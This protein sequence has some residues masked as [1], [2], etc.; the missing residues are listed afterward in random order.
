[1]ARSRLRLKCDGSRAETRFRLS[2]KRTSPFKSSGGRQFS[3]LLAAEVCTSAAIMLDTPCSEVVWK[4]L[5]TNSIRQF[6]FHFPSRASPYVITFQLDSSTVHA[7]CTLKY[8]HN[9]HLYTAGF[10]TIIHIGTYDEKNRLCGLCDHRISFRL[11]SH[12]L[13]YKIQHVR[14]ALELDYSCDSRLIPGIFKRTR[15][16]WF[17]K[18]E[19]CTN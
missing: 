14:R 15:N 7:T 17:H 8:V 9:V 5:A 4:V 10:L 1:M 2:A 19:F 11:R 13:P 16:S 3:W 12:C 18:A 6:P